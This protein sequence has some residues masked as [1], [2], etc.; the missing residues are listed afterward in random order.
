MATGQAPFAVST[1]ARTSQQRG[2]EKGRQP[3]LLCS[4]RWKA[5]NRIPLN[6][7]WRFPSEYIFEW[8]PIALCKTV[9][10]L[11]LF[12]IL[13]LGLVILGNLLNPQQHFATMVQLLTPFRNMQEFCCS[14]S[15][16]SSFGFGLLCHYL[17][18]FTWP[19]IWDQWLHSN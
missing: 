4:F 16:L 12:T 5:P 9:V 19:E 14:F 2:P 13:S 10:L 15:N 18:Q 3:G 7:A 1:A 8:R 6:K 11:L 17:A